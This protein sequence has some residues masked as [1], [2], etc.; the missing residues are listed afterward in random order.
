[1]RFK[2]RLI[3]VLV[4]M[5]PL[6]FAHAIPVTVQFT[7]TGFAATAPESSV[8]GTLVFEGAGV[9]S[10]IDS[11]TSL[12]LTIGG[13]NY[14]LGEVGFVSPFGTNLNL[15]GGTLSGVNGI[16]HGSTDFWLIWNMPTLT[17]SSFAY[18]V[19]GGNSNFWSTTNFSNFSITTSVDEPSYLAMLGLGLLAMWFFR[20]RQAKVRLPALA[21]PYVAS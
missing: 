17:G 16:L 18:S 10:T 3:A 5:A 7:A 4:L 9:N 20:R 12:N 15:V 6:G 11:L 13:H 2:S 1:M 19:P 8:S 21:S 14:A